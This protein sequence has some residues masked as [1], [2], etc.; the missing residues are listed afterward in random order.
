MP[1]HHGVQHSLPKPPLLSRAISPVTEKRTRHRKP[2]RGTHLMGTITTWR[3]YNGSQDIL[4]KHHSD[5]PYPDTHSVNLARK[6]QV[7]WVEMGKTKKA[8]KWNSS[9]IEFKREMEVSVDP[10]ISSI[11]LEIVQLQGTS[12]LICGFITVCFN[13]EVSSPNGSDF[14]HQP[15]GALQEMTVL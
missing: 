11:I 4:R 15:S 6:G 1:S 8:M 2:S 5:D 13:F 14:P 3:S 9:S 7:L 10:I 12:T